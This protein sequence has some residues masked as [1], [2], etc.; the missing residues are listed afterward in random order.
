MYT[1]MKCV[2][3]QNVLKTYIK[4]SCF[5]APLTLCLPSCKLLQVD[6]LEVQFLFAYSAWGR[7]DFN[8][9]L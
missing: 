5:L 2:L 9:G 1:A 7:V 3:N 4:I 8:P 6:N